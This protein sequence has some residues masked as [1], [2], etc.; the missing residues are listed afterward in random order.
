MLGPLPEP[1]SIAWKLWPR[2]ITAADRPGDSHAGAYGLSLHA[3]ESRERRRTMQNLYVPP[4]CDLASTCTEMW[5]TRITTVQAGSGRHC[6]RA[7]GRL[8]YGAI[9]CFDNVDTVPR[10]FPGTC[11]SAPKEGKAN[12]PRCP[13]TAGDFLL[14]ARSFPRTE[15]HRHRGQHGLPLAAMLTQISDPKF[16]FS[17]ARYHGDEHDRRGARTR[18]ASIAF[19]ALHYIA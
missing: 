5:P 12:L 10:T 3:A 6:C 19:N 2:S 16:R 13:S 4:P 18:K 17:S 15:Y 1:P 7:M 11:C 8:P 14:S 9:G